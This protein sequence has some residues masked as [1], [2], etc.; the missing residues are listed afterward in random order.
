MSHLLSQEV[1]GQ[2]LRG[3]SRIPIN[4]YQGWRACLELAVPSSVMSGGGAGCQLDFPRLVTCSQ[5]WPSP[6][7]TPENPSICS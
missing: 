2:S 4:H 1:E 3:P 7:L 5:T 6:L